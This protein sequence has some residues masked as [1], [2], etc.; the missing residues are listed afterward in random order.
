MN[1]F[2]GP[3]APPFVGPRVSLSAGFFY[4]FSV[5][6]QAN[7]SR[8]VAQLMDRDADFVWTAVQLVS[9]ANCGVRFKDHTGFYFSSALLDT[10]LMSP[11]SWNG[12]FL[13]LP[14]WPEVVI[15]A[16]GA[17]EMDVQNNN[18]GPVVLSLLL[19]GSKRFAGARG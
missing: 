13:G 5:T 4:L 16:A 17:I 11:I 6:L 9:G 14:V 3:N 1:Q 18:A 7:E 8:T 2:T 15:P 12:P 19:R 10:S